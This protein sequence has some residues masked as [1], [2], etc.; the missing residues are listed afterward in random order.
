MTSQR[1]SY[2]RLTTYLQDLTPLVLQAELINKPFRYSQAV[3]E[4][5]SKKRWVP[6]KDS[7]RFKYDENC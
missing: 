5:L 3:T 2:D 4:R 1:F 6:F 7:P